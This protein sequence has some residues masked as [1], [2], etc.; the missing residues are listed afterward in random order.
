M[1]DINP[2]EESSNEDDEEVTNKKF[3]EKVREYNTG[4]RDT[5]PFKELPQWKIW[6]AVALLSGV[7]VI[8][9]ALLAAGNMGAAFLVFSAPFIGVLILTETGREF[10]RVLQ[11]EMEEG[12]QQQ[13]DTS[14][15]EPKK[16]CPD[17]GWQNPNEGNYCHDCG[18]ELS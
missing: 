12:N 18:S 1:S 17:C 14:G 11:E 8:G 5:N 3:Y 9:F 13:Q 10:L 16:V 15:I 2:R 7:V 4:K 6:G